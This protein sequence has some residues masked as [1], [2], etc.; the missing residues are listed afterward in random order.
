VSQTKAQLLD[1]SVVAVSFGAGSAAAP[2]INYSADTTTGIYFP[3]ATQLAFSTAGVQR[4][5]INGTGNVNIPGT[6]S[7]T[8]Q[9]TAASGSVSTPSILLNGGGSPGIYSPAANQLAIVGGGATFL[10]ASSGAIASTVP[11]TAPAGSATATAV[12]VGTGTTYAPGIYSPGTDQLAISTSGSGRLFV[13][14]S[15]NLG[16]GGLPQSDATYGGFTLNGANGAI[17][18]LRAGGANSGRIYTSATDNINIDGNG[19]ASTNI[20]FRTGTGSTERMRIDSSGNL[21]IGVAPSAWVDDKALQIGYGAISSGYEY[22]ISTTA[23]AFRSTTNT[24]KYLNGQAAFRSNINNGGFQWFTAPSGTAGNAITFTQAMTL[25]A[26]GNLGV[27]GAITGTALIPSGSSAPTNGIY[28]P[29]ANTVA[30]ATNGS[31]KLVVDGSGNVGIAVTPSAWSGLYSL[32]IG[33]TGSSLAS[34]A[35]DNLYLTSGAYYNGTNWIYKASSQLVSSYQQLSGIHRW[36]IAPSGTAGG[37]VSFTQAMTLDASGRLGLGATS[38]T[39]TLHVENTNL[40]NP[41]LTWGANATQTIRVSGI[42]ELALG[43]TG[44]APYD[45]YLQARNNASAAQALLLNPAGGNVGINTAS[46]QKTLDVF[47]KIQGRP[48]TNGLGSTD[49]FITGAIQETNDFGVGLGIYVESA[50]GNAYALTFGTKPNSGTAITERMR[51]DANGRLLVGTTSSRIGGL[52]TFVSGT[53]NTDADVPGAAASFVAPGLVGTFTNAATISVEDNRNMAIDVGGSIGFGGRYLTSSTAYAQ[54][55]AIAGKKSTGTSGEYGGYLGFYTRTHATSTIDE[56][57]RFDSSGRLLV[58]T[59]TARSG[60][61]S[62]A[63]GTALQ[64]EGSTTNTCSLSITRNA[65]DADSSKLVLAH[66]RG[67]A[68]QILVNG[69]SIGE[70]S[71]QGAD[72]AQL[73]QAAQITGFAD[74]APGSS[75]MPGRLVFS[76]TLSGQSSP[77]ERM[78]IT[79][80]GSIYINQT[81][82]LQSTKPIFEAKGSVNVVCAYMSAADNSGY[83]ALRTRLDNTTG[84]YHAIFTYQGTTI[85]TISSTNSG[86]AYNIVSDYRLK[87]NVTQVLDGIA[88]FKQLKP[89]RFNFISDPDRTVD[90]FLAHEAQAVVPE[91]VTGE[92]DAVD[93]DGNPVYQGIDQSKLVPLLTAALQEAIARIETLEAD[94]AALKGA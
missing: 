25:D 36:N 71:W 93:A 20:I 10:T 21:G 42:R 2:S 59:S 46:P 27:G 87:E 74:G 81:D 64:I 56:R 40:T 29:S 75:S 73:V 23:N 4:L 9:I 41:S 38:P 90:G 14:A 66:A 89:S 76:T 44:A 68:N 31:G 49:W 35:N 67:T 88:R 52:G 13:D 3:A 18:T 78:R 58:G 39:Q 70:I 19:S 85:G 77:T 5:A 69:D 28:L 80:A 47:G 91:C 84:N 16:V 43:V 34:A 65:V 24:W 51:V 1:G 30:V 17:I 86:V 60:F 22:G 57:G 12:A 62:S 92:K 7:V 32:S 63:V 54:W 55:A 53:N 48:I 94:V 26:S 37:A 6:F 61:Y 83:A 50:G 45:C 15:G 72:G 82:S 33:S 79:N 11:F 8:G